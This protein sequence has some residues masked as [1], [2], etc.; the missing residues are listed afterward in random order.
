MEYT[1]LFN[2]SDVPAT[3]RERVAPK[4]TFGDRR[5]GRIYIYDAETELAVNLALAADRPLL[6]RGP[7]GS[8]K[9][10]LAQSVAF[11]KGWRYYEAVIS[12]RSQAEDLLW[13]FDAVRR[14]SDALDAARDV[15]ARSRYLEPGV[16]WWAFDRESARQQ[17]GAADP[18]PWPASASNSRAVVLIDE[19]DK[20]DPD[21]PN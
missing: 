4:S 2:A 10:S 7:S 8:G 21:V 18:T 19:I 17:T 6:V 5:D 15:S 1:K 14:L 16:L 20:A 11:I 12:S 3:S 13:R 9:S